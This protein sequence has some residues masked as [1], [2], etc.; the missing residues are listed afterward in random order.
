MK[1]SLHS[2]LLSMGF[3]RKRTTVYPLEWWALMEMLF[4][5][6]TCPEWA[7]PAI[8]MLEWERGVDSTLRYTWTWIDDEL[9]EIILRMS[10]KG[11]M[12]FGDAPKDGSYTLKNVALGYRQCLGICEALVGVSEAEK[13]IIDGEVFYTPTPLMKS[14]LYEIATRRRRVLVIQSDGLVRGYKC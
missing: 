1:F 7:T 8:R 5:R 14:H 13:K 11:G 3:S 9:G 6:M 2:A 12:W 10:S 4:E